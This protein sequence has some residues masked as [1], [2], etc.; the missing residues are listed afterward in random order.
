MPQSIY[1]ALT[2]TMALGLS[3][4][5][6]AQ[7]GLAAAPMSIAV[8]EATAIGATCSI[9]TVDG[10]TTTAPCH[11]TGW[12]AVLGPGWSAQMTATIHY[13]Y[14]DDG[15]SLELSVP[16]S[17]LSQFQLDPFGFSILQLEFEAGAI[18]TFTNQTHCHVRTSPCGNIAPGGN[19]LYFGEYGYPPVFV[20]HNAFAEDVSGDISVTTGVQWLPSSIY[21]GQGFTWSHT[22]F[23][24]P[25]A[26]VVFAIPEPATWALMI[27]PLLGLGWLCRRRSATRQA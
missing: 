13:N 14:S 24:D 4:P 3:M 9:T 20:S 7:A 26:Q 12:T 5:A 16:P 10:A 6:P 11:P 25:S 2:V 1:L 19:D 17:P 8:I 21:Y 18:Y 23:V 27:G 22:L 15:L